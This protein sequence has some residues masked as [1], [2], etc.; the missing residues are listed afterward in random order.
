MLN[1]ILSHLII[2]DQESLSKGHKVPSY[3]ATAFIV[4]FAILNFKLLV[5]GLMIYSYKMSDTS[6]TDWAT[7]VAA[8]S[9]MLIANKHINN[10]QTNKEQQ[11]KQDD[12]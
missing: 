6:I 10:I 5:S 4:G 1:K 3:T 12:K 9:A 8:L 2:W 7:G 11:I